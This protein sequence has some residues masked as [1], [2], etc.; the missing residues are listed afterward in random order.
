[1]PASRIRMQYVAS[2][3]TVQLRGL[4]CQEYLPGSNWDM[5]RSPSDLQ[6]QHCPPHNPSLQGSTPTALM[7]VIVMRYGLKIALTSVLPK[8]IQGDSQGDSFV[9][10]RLLSMGSGCG[11][12]THHRAHQ[13][14][15]SAAV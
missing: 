13:Q 7:P 9:A 10:L 6:S 15:P 4:K 11:G 14:A 8:K 12:M 2:W 5:M 3:G 1:M